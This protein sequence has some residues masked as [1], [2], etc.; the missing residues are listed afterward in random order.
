MTPDGEG[1]LRT[2][3]LLRDRVHDWMKHPFTIQAIRALETLTIHPRVTFFVGENGCGKSTLIEAI[4][5]IAGFNPEGGTRSFNFSTRRSDS[6][7]HT[8]LRV[9]RGARRERTGYFLRAESFFNVATEI[10]RLDREPGGPPIILSYGGKSLH[11]QSHGESFLALIKNRF[12]PDGLYILDEPEAALSPG[13][14]LTLLARIHEL[15]GR[16][17]SQFIIA[18]HSPIVLAYPDAIIY[19]LSDNG[20]EP[21]RYE[22]TEQYFL[23]REFLLHRERFFDELFDRD[24]SGG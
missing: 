18:T 13:R 19:K 1:Y 7:L 8:A 9:A 6:E 15:V 12:G 16:G 5:I 3:S 24:L 4:A 23:T 14:Q 21:V 11:E 17:R 22:E 2:V 20:I 10:E